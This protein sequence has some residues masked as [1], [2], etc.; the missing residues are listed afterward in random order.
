MAVLPLANDSD[1]SGLDRAGGSL[2]EVASSELVAKP[3][4]TLVER[5]RLNDILSELKLGSSGVVDEATAAKVGRLVGADFM[6]FGS[7]SDL[8][9]RWLLTMRMVR[10][11]TGEIVNAVV[12]RG[13]RP[14]DLDGMAR[15]AIRGVLPAA[16]AAAAE[17]SPAAR[18]ELADGLPA[19]VRAR[20]GALGVVVSVRDYKNKD[21]PRAEFARADARLMKRYLTRSLGYS[22]DNIIELDDPTKAEMETVFG[23]A[24]DPHGRLSRL[25]DLRG[26]GS[27][28][29]FVYYS[30]HGAPSVKTGRS[31]LVPADANPDYVEL[32][33]YPR[34]VL[35]KNLSALGAR[36]VTV[37]LES[38][39]SGG[40]G[41]GALIHDASPLVLRAAESDVPSGVNLITASSGGQISSWYPEKGHSLFTYFLIRDLSRRSAAQSWP[42]T[43]RNVAT[44]VS[45]Q[46]AKKYNRD[47]VPEFSGGGEGLLAR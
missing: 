21:V 36:R 38:C 3:G 11:E 19:A 16:G 42:E 41:G 17:A 10:V 24:G 33:G 2:A 12:Q 20:P 26:R 8:G 30:G 25:L 29:V 44:E 1:Q 7:F 37:V 15:A 45:A 18:D 5:R 22:E 31:Y 9:G 34:D 4:I 40:S 27:S 6:A 14:E 47:Q 23:G 43:A 39:F 13:S 35:L 32:N 28:E 46:A